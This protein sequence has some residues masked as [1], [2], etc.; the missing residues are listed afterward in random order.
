MKLLNY[1]HKEWIMKNVRTI[2]KEV[3]PTYTKSQY[4]ICK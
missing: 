2:T 4:Y 3:P 1:D